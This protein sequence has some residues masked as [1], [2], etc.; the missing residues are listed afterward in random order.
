MSLLKLDQRIS[1]KRKALADAVDARNAA[2]EAL[3]ALSD[4]I[5]ALEAADGS[6]EK[7]IAAKIAEMKTAR[8]SAFKAGDQVRALESEISDLELERSERQANS[9][10]AANLRQPL[11]RQTDSDNP[12]AVNQ[13]RVKGPFEG[14]PKEVLQEDL[15]AYFQAAYLAKKEN[16]NI[17]QVLRGD[18]GEQFK[19]DRLYAATTSNNSSLVPVIYA[20]TLIEL[21]RPQSVVASLPGVRRI[22]IPN[23]NLTLPRQ[24]TGGSASYLGEQVNAVVTDVTSDAVVLSAKKLVSMTPASGELM[25]RSDPSAMAMVRDDIINRTAERMDI[26]FI[27][28]TANTTTTPKGFKFFAELNSNAGRVTA[29]STINLANVTRDIGLLILR[30]RSINCPFRNPV[31]IMSPRTERY[32]MDVRDGNGNMGFPEMTRGLLRQY[33]YRVTTQIP[34]NLTT[35]TV[36][37][38]SELYFVDASEILLGETPTMELQVSTEAAYHDGSNVVAAYS[39]DTA[40]FRMIVE[41]DLQM[42]HERSVA[43]MEQVNWS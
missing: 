31:F 15:G 35:N 19:N 2:F 37:N 36:P 7:V 16:V 3:D 33:P 24:A 1:A 9:Q 21:L 4:E 26:T 32:L 30:L 28:N 39:Q 23:G 11:P 8:Q 25:R 14:V 27:R 13:P 17:A 41:H 18:I 34:E 6:D 5:E 10:T 22:S 43:F 38:C 42:R 29:N 12:S 20:R 40:V